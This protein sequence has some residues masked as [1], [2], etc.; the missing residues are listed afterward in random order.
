MR[1]SD[2]LLRS[3]FFGAIPQLDLHGTLVAEASE[4]I[5]EFLDPF[6]VSG[7]HVRIVGGLGAWKLM[8]AIERHLGSLKRRHLIRDFWMEETAASFIVHL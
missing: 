8:P 5:N 7:G 3:L 1:L 6:F 2:D 4:R